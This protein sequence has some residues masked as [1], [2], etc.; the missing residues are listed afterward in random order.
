M[1]LTSGV[2]SLIG[3]QASQEVKTWN[4]EEAT[5]VDGALEECS[6]QSPTG[7]KLRS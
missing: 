3:S 1:H 4:K 7:L 2:G 6:R 5:Q